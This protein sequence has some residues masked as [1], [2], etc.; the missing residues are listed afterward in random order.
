MLARSAASALLIH[1]IAL[2]WTVW[3][4]DEAVTGRF[5]PYWTATWALIV[6]LAVPV[7]V[8]TILHR[9]AT[10]QRPKWLASTVRFAGLSHHMRLEDAW[11]YVFA[12]EQ[13]AW[14]RVHKT[15]GQIIVGY[16][17]PASFGSR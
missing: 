6:L 7:A 1:A 13:A 4:V 2:P 17:G 12:R 9:T 10:T 14:V 5:R 16:F 11:A 8:G 15:D 3:L